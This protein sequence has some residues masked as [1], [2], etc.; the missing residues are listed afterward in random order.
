[1]SKKNKI[2]YIGD[3]CGDFND[4][5]QSLHPFFLSSVC[6]FLQPLG[7]PTSCGININ[8]I[9]KDF[10]L[11]ILK[12]VHFIVLCELFHQCKNIVIKAMLTQTLQPLCDLAATDFV[13]TDPRPLKPMKPKYAHIWKRIRITDKSA[14][15]RRRRNICF[16]F[17]EMIGDQ[18][19]TTVRDL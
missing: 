7:A 9:N 18:S 17:D 13:A 5:S 1:M 8:Y 10:S 2:I 6:C 14:T 19:A 15:D 3:F 4:F 16:R 11:R 12:Y